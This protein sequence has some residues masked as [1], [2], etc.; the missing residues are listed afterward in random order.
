MPNGLVSIAVS[1]GFPAVLD[2]YRKAPRS[3]DWAL[4][5]FTGHGEVSCM[6]DEKQ[7]NQRNKPTPSVPLVRASVEE[8]RKIHE[9]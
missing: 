2:F 9:G 5:T 7:I 3:C 1:R 8:Q 4:Y 6:R